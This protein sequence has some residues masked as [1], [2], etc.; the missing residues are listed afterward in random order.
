MKSNVLLLIALLLLMVSSASGEQITIEITA[1]VA[2]VSG[3][4]FGIAPAW[5][6]EVSGTFVF[7]TSTLDSNPDGDRG[8]YPHTGNGAFTV[9][10]EGHA[11]TVTGSTTPWIQIENLAPDTFRFIDGPR[12]SGPMGGIMSVNGLADPDIQLRIEVTD[13]SGAAFDDDSLPVEFPFVLPGDPH[14]FSLKDDQG[15]LLL[16]FDEVVTPT[17][18]LSWGYLKSMFDGG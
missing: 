4:P 1:H 18:T 15:T 10:I 5:G 12:T 6:T 16:Q 9:V 8:D 3:T 2:T 14:T 13:E 11:V 17:E 7:D